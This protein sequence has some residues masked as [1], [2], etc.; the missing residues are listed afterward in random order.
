MIGI[1]KITNIQNGRM[2]IGQSNNIER[3]FKEHQTKGAKS[4]I[5]VDVAI[6][7]HGKKNFIYEVLEEC[8][9]EELDAREVFWIDYFNSTK[10]GYNFSTGGKQQ[11]RGENN[12]RALVTE[13]DVRK[14]RTAYLARRKRREVYQDFK[15]KITFNTFAKI[16]DGTQ[17]SHIMPEIFTAESKEF[18]SK[19]ASNGEL[20]A[21]AKFSNEEVIALRER[22][23]NETA[24]EIYKGL[25][26]RCSYQTL[27]AIL[28]GRSY[29]DLP[30]YKKKQKEWTG[31]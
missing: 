27:Q 10:K 18:Y 21:S 14:I 5:L 20:S 1:Y 6:K 3:R 12:G 7:K 4:R 9:S 30:V 23:A 22:Y 15:D 17:W 28:W 31:K 29:K 26:E 2:Y 13:E 8:L 25:E 19:Q 11:S 24:K 16:W